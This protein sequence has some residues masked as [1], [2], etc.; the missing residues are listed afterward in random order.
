MIRLF[1]IS[2]EVHIQNLLEGC[3]LQ[4]YFVTFLATEYAGLKQELHQ[5]ESLAFS[6][7]EHGY[8]MLVL[9][10]SDNGN[11]AFGNLGVNDLLDSGPEYVEIVRL[12]DE[13]SVFRAC[14]L[15]DNECLVMLYAVKGT[16]EPQL[17][18][19]LSSFAEEAIQ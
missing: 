14:F 4:P 8:C 3:T 6:L 15:L 16:L 17:E 2:N 5:E 1:T 12:S 7:N 11:S 9:E 18:R 10:T 19:R 13:V